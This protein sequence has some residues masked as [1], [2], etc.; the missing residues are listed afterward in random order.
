MSRA[1]LQSVQLKRDWDFNQI[2]LEISQLTVTDKLIYQD[3]V[4]LGY[5]II[6]KRMSD[7]SLIRTMIHASNKVDLLLFDEKYEDALNL[8]EQKLKENP[9]DIEL[10]F[11]QARTLMG[12]DREEEALHVYKEALNVIEREIARNPDHIYLQSQRAQALW[13]C[14]RR[15]ESLAVERN[16]VKQTPENDVAWN[17]L[18]VSLS[19][20][21]KKE[22]ALSAIKKASSLSPNRISYLHTKHDLLMDMGRTNDAYRVLE[23]VLS[24]APVTLEDKVDKALFMEKTGFESLEDLRNHRKQ[25]SA[26]RYSVDIDSLYNPSLN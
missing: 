22:E 14:G 13:F 3:P 26:V 20:L 2:R 23:S 17:N 6:I 16:I 15:E 5:L 8:A 4:N 21:G 9:N 10:K 1:N 19:I 24:A 12:C 25:I 18:A 11:Q 7:G